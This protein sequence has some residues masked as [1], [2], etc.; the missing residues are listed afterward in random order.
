[1]LIDIQAFEVSVCYYGYCRAA[2][3][4]VGFITH[5]VP[6]GKFALLLVDGKHGIDKVTGSFGLKEGEQRVCR[7]V[8]IPQREGGVIGERCI[9][10]DLLI[11]TAIILINV[12]EGRRGNHGMIKGGVESVQ[13]AYGRHYRLLPLPCSALCSRRHRLWLLSA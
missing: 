10:M 8:G 3:H 13:C 9:G 2:N 5:Q 11:C 6:H 12:T 4:T 7:T 1:F